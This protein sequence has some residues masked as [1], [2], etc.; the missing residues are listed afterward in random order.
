M[1]RTKKRKETTTE[2]AS[3]TE[4]LSEQT[5]ETAENRTIDLF[6]GADPRISEAAIDGETP[7]PERF[8]CFATNCPGYEY[9]ADVQAHPVATCGT[10]VNCV[11]L[12]KTT[13]P[14]ANETIAPID[15]TQA[16]SSE[17]IPASAGEDL[18]EIEPPPVTTPGLEAPIDG[19]ELAPERVDDKV[20]EL[21]VPEI[22]SLWEY[23]A[24]GWLQLVE[25][26]GISGVATVDPLTQ[27]GVML[28][29]T[30]LPTIQGSKSGSASGAFF[31]VDDFSN[32]R[33][34]SWE[35]PVP[36]WI[37]K[38][39]S[40]AAQAQ[41]TLDQ[42]E[43]RDFSEVFPDTPILEEP[44]D[45]AIEPSSYT[46][47]PELDFDAVFNTRIGALADELGVRP[48]H[49]CRTVESIMD[50]GVQLLTFHGNMQSSPAV[51]ALRDRV[52]QEANQTR[53]VMA[54]LMA[55]GRPLLAKMFERT[56]QEFWELKAEELHKWTIQGEENIAEF[57]TQL[58]AV[59]ADVESFTKYATADASKGAVDLTAQ[60]LSKTEAHV[61]KVGDRVFALESWQKRIQQEI[62]NYARSVKLQKHD[63]K[64]AAQRGKAFRER[65]KRL[66]VENE[67]NLG[68]VRAQKAE[69]ERIERTGKPKAKPKPKA[70]PP[71]KRGRGRP[72][73]VHNAAAAAP[74]RGRGRPP[75]VTSLPPKRGRGRPPKA[76]T[77]GG[78]RTQINA[79]MGINGDD[80]I[81]KLLLAI[82]PDKLAEFLKQAK[83]GLPDMV[84][85][86]WGPAQMSTFAKWYYGRQLSK[87]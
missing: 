58:H 42:V 20:S 56:A 62:G 78:T 81:L 2:P 46:E 44:N 61:D 29:S 47:A 69:A 23:W 9:R 49:I 8:Y 54:A 36:G 16:A 52:M 22:G 76:P 68:L 64:S 60:A 85:V 24:N 26:L 40:S 48:T 14:P 5:L 77:E 57:R 15:E 34:V 79:F 37:V 19:A 25:V 33:L 72:P 80:R 67:R 55:A 75:K 50:L 66:K 86:K 65:E 12:H 41:L 3:T 82:K 39:L 6:D 73:K 71:V 1:S 84:A 28:Y 53:G 11:H 43:E 21:F 87:R 70:P 18:A 51:A 74:K 32:G 17:T 30:A 35:S 63:P 27:V 38:E 10:I 4:D 83:V 13:P 59:K 45:G 31:N 7:K